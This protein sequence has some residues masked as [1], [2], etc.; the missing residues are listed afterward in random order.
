VPGPLPHILRPVVGPADPAHDEKMRALRG[1]LA[2]LPAYEVA[3]FQDEV[4][5]DLNPKVGS[6]APK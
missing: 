2:G 5:L 3:V 4:Q 6:A 1:L